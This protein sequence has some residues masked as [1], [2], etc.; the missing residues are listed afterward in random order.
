M[1]Q[2]DEHHQTESCLLNFQP[3]CNWTSKRSIN[4]VGTALDFFIMR[5]LVWV[6]EAS[7]QAYCSPPVWGPP[8]VPS[9]VHYGS[10]PEHSAPSQPVYPNPHPGPP[11]PTPTA[12]LENTAPARSTSSNTLFQGATSLLCIPPACISLETTAT[13]PSCTDPSYPC[14]SSIAIYTTRL[15]FSE[16]SRTLVSHGS[17][18][19]QRGREIN[20]SGSTKTPE[21]FSPR[22]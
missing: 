21:S 9:T 7:E 1:I 17:I 16:V 22:Q 3:Y 12:L 10:L 14:S 5:I 19:Q 11:P 18:E 6:W 15:H 8:P 2:D 4:K 20:E 13:A